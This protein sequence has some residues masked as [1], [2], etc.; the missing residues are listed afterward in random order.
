MDSLVFSV[1]NKTQTEGIVVSNN[2]RSALRKI[3]KLSEDNEKDEILLDLFEN[4]VNFCLDQDF[5]LEKISCALGILNHLF[6]DSITKNIPQGSCEETFKNL[7]KKHSIQRP[8]FS[9]QVYSAPELRSLENFINSRFFKYYSLLIYC[10]TPHKDVIIT[11]E[12]LECGR[13][14]QCLSLIDSLEINPETIPELKLYFPRKQSP[15]ERQQDLGSKEIEA[16]DEEVLDPAQNFLNTEIK[17]VKSHIEE[18]V[19][20]QDEEIFARIESLKK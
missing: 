9:I 16:R 7:L 18:K 5:T 12:K 20:K 1:F 4:L 3:L 10:Y 14:P 19:K 2:K 15:K 13:F 11:T 6:Q 17:A 8:P